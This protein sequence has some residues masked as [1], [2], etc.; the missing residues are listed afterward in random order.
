M[1]SRLIF[2]HGV[3]ILKL[4]LETWSPGFAEGIFISEHHPV[5]VGPIVSDSVLP[6]TMKL[7][8]LDLCR[9]LSC[10]LLLQQECFCLRESP[11]Y[12]CHLTGPLCM[13]HMWLFD[14]ELCVVDS[15]S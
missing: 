14:L 11:G 9:L 12:L 7:F 5:G 6:S 15:I 3:D 13:G 2:R 4:V 8:T 1:D 10:W